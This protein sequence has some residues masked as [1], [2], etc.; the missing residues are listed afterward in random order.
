VPTRRLLRIVLAVAAVAAAAAA[1]I[2]V[3][4]AL[5]GYAQPRNDPVGKLSPLA[6]STPAPV[7]LPETVPAGD[8]DNDH[9]D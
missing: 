6:V 1:A 3:N 8:D 2:L 9:D 4:L 5:L 7:S